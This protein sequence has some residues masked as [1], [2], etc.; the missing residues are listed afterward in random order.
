MFFIEFVGLSDVG[1]ERNHNGSCR[2]CQEK[3]YEASPEVSINTV[4]DHSLCKSNDRWVQ[5]TFQE[6]VKHFLITR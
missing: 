2:Y 5:S 4:T 6:G 3:P 1:C